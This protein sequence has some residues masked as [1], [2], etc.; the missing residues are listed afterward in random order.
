MQRPICDTSCRY[1]RLLLD[2]SRC[3]IVS[4]VFVLCLMSI[5]FVVKAW[6]RADRTMRASNTRVVNFKFVIVYLARSIGYQ[7]KR[8]RAQEL[9]GHP[10]SLRLVGADLGA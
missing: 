7:P 10:N 3:T 1:R 2:S 4:T 5:F 6:R 8:S 9:F